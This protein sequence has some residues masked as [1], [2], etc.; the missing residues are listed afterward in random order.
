MKK[1]LLLNPPG[2]LPYHRDYYCSETS[3]GFYRFH[4][5]DLVYL[6]G[7]LKECF[8]IAFIDSIVEKFTSE[9]TI[10]KIEQIEPDIIIFLTSAPSYNEDD[11]F[12][13]VLKK[14][15]PNI[16]LIGTGDIYRELKEKAF[17]KQFFLDAIILDFSTRDI[18]EFL[19]RN[20]KKQINNIIYKSNGEIIAGKEKHESGI[21]DIPIP[22][23]DLINLKRYTFPFARQKKYATILTDF[24][25][26]F[27]C[28]FCPISTLGFKVRRI[29]NVINEIKS[30]GQLGV[31]EIFFRDQT[32][33]TKK[34]RTIEL[35]NKMI[36]ENLNLSWT[37]L[38]RVDVISDKILSL[39]KRAGCHTIILGIE[40]N[41][42]E[43]LKKYIKN[44][45]I[46]QVKNAIHLCK[47]NKLRIV[48]TF[49]LGFPED[50][51][52][53]IE[54]TIEF[55]KDLNLDFVSFNIFSPQFGT[56]FRKKILQDKLINCEVKNINPNGLPV[57]EKFNLS[58]QKIFDLHTRANRSF[59][60]RPNYLIK[61]FCSINTIYELLILIKN[62]IFLLLKQ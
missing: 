57:W 59:Y 14:K 32:F 46:F 21:F 39:M 34:E 1:I 49:M 51:E 43:L 52:N 19:N 22:R 13:K 24:G 42:D 3:K 31:K 36:S 2:K 41:S 18:L 54:K 45:T 6:S 40:S 47:K 33:G 44:I 15:I 28:I 60:L 29:D 5:V 20:D 38:S 9:K 37:C 61:R 55:S 27:S 35:L 17:S 10:L 23:W 8:E 56:T 16:V 12:F 4:P 7:I 50:T 58:N 53:S 11:E 48:G 25:C 26:A 62:G 30:L